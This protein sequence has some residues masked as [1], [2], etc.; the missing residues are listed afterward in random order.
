MAK[1]ESGRVNAKINNVSSRREM[2]SVI[3]SCAVKE[4]VGIFEGNGGCCGHGRGPSH[5]V[6]AQGQGRPTFVSASVFIIAFTEKGKELVTYA[7][8]CSPSAVLAELTLQSTFLGSLEES[9]SGDFTVMHVL[10]KCT[11]AQAFLIGHVVP[12]KLGFKIQE[13]CHT[14]ECCA[15]DKHSHACYCRRFQIKVWWLVSA[16]STSKTRNVTSDQERRRRTRG[17]AANLD[18]RLQISKQK[19]KF[20]NITIL[21]TA[22]PNA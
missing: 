22:K 19:C 5:D 12:F 10:R 3:F 13:L 2:S 9:W 20:W 8:W 16:T 21:E 17:T 11:Q 4:N 18:T 14:N 7:P 6:R 1:I 15:W